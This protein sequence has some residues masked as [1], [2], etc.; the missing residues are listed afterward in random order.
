M[1][2]APS[3]NLELKGDSVMEEEYKDPGF[4]RPEV[5]SSASQVGAITDEHPDQ[6]SELEMLKKRVDE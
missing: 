6:N 4:F 1:I 3:E 5:V 2:N